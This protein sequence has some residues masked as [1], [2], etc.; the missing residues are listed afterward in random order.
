MRH[1]RDQRDKE[2]RADLIVLNFNPPNI[3]QSR[4]IHTL[5][6]DQ[7]IGSVDGIMTNATST[8]PA[9]RLAEKHFKNRA[10]AA[11]PA[12]RDLPPFCRA[13]LDLS[14]PDSCEDDEIWRAGWWGRTYE[15]PAAG[16]GRKPKRARER[17]RGERPPLPDLGAEGVRSLELGDGR[18]GY[19]VAEGGSE[20]CV[21]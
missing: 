3:N 13:V 4:H 10:T 21:S 18:T 15:P 19:V 1:R 11:L 16:N 17:A 20:L 6:F 7:R 9:F 8:H 5:C 14:R 12:L 2:F